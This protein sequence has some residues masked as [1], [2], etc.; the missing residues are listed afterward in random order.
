ML[1]ELTEAEVN[2]LGGL[3]HSHRNSCKG[4]I[5]QSK[6]TWGKVNVDDLRVQIAHSEKIE[7]ILEGKIPCPIC[8]AEGECNGGKCGNCK[9][10]K[11]V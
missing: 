3:L 1:I 10:K 7:A 9:G 4:R 6:R 11:Y 8:E 5:A 2:F